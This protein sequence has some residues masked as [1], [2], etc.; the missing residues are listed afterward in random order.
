MS[1][2]FRLGFARRFAPGFARG[3]A[4]GGAPNAPIPHPDAVCRATSVP[5]SLRDSGHRT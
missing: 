1:D 2:P 4:Q 3:F 5:T